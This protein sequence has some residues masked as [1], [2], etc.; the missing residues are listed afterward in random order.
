MTPELHDW[1]QRVMHD[2]ATGDPAYAAMGLDSDAA[3]VLR[4][5]GWHTI[6]VASARKSVRL[7]S[8]QD[9]R[10]AVARTPQWWTEHGWWDRGCWADSSPRLELLSP[11]QAAALAEAGVTGEQEF[12]RRFNE[13]C[14]SR[15][16][17][18]VDIRP[19]TA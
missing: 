19:H 8:V 9:A 6:H 11:G 17:E 18:T 3:E 16:G 1:A 5:A 7:D 13:A 4:S 12:R 10:E 15:R 2:L 14:A